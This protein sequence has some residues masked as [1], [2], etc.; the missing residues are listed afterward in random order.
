[1][2]AP[3]ECKSCGNLLHNN[4][5]RCPYCGTIVPGQKSLGGR[6]DDVLGFK[7][8]SEPSSETRRPA[9]DSES[10]INW[11]VMI[12]LIIVFW[13]AAIIYALVKSNK[14]KL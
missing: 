11:V 13:P 7:S 3:I 14:I 6:L 2:G 12:I 9:A 8:P 4:E 10:G 5:N 1:M